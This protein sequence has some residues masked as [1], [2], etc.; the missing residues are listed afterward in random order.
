[1]SL[2][3]V[4]MFRTDTRA[5]E[6]ASGADAKQLQLCAKDAYSEFMRQ[7]TDV[8]WDMVCSIEMSPSLISTVLNGEDSPDL[9]A[10]VI[11]HQKVNI[12]HITQAL[13]DKDKYVADVA[14]KLH[15]FKSIYVRLLKMHRT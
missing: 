8:K 6:I 5:K 7:S 15:P 1:M 12:S 3:A 10:A 14:E 2:V 9:K 4:L 11:L 13:S